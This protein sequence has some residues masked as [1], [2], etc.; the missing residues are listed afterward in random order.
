M[1][2]FQC[3]SSIER[4]TIVIRRHECQIM[5]YIMANQ[6]DYNRGTITMTNIKVLLSMLYCCLEMI[7]DGY[8][9]TTLL[10]SPNDT[11][12]EFQ[13]SVLSLFSTVEVTGG[14]LKKNHH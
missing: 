10:F 11:L 12:P 13:A 6:L 3:N 5:R 2:D 9:S 14:S 1:K 4:R 7:Y 8:Y